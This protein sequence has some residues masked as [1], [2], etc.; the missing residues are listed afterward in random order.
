MNY[1]QYND[2][3]LKN[4]LYKN[5]NF[6][7]ELICVKNLPNTY[8]DQND[9][10]TYNYVNCNNFLNNNKDYQ[11]TVART[12]NQKDKHIS[13]DFFAVM[14]KNYRSPS[15]KEPGDFSKHVVSMIPIEQRYEY[16]NPSDRTIPKKLWYT[17]CDNYCNHQDKVE[18][19][20]KEC[21]NP[22]SHKMLKNAY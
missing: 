9:F 19:C 1:N 20:K 4:N 11:L 14:P 2:F 21:K 17:S 3:L 7:D 13:N 15:I 22:L 5:P 18:I 12:T 8:Q 10:N 16:D 6:F